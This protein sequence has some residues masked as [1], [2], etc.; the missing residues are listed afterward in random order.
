M[1]GRR[2]ID[3]G[4]VFLHLSVAAALIGGML[5]LAR[6]PIPAATVLLIAGGLFV[7]GRRT[8]PPVGPVLS[9]PTLPPPDAPDHA[10]PRATSSPDDER[11]EEIPHLPP[12][13]SGTAR[14]PWAPPAR[15]VRVLSRRR[16][17][18]ALQRA[19]LRAPDVRATLVSD[20]AS[21]HHP[22]AVAVFVEDE[23]VGDL[24]G[25]DV[26]D[27]GPALARA[28]CDI[29]AEALLTT[30]ALDVALPDP[31]GLVPANDV[32][33]GIVL[34][35]GAHLRVQPL[36]DDV[37]RAAA[38]EVF[39]RYPGGV[40][41]AVSV[42]SVR[43]GRRNEPVRAVRVDLDGVLVGRL[44]GPEADDLI[45]LLA[46]CEDRHRGVVAAA[47]QDGGGRLT[48]SCIRG[49]DADDTW[50]RTVR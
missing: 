2:R 18:A 40:W 28:G 35:H 29:A 42:T 16:H 48:L 33:D 27:Y 21:P 37:E 15:R 34:P 19:R 8:P 31:V 39:A 23:H 50:L 38:E 22:Y 32:P 6:Q 44:T 10:G 1:A 43:P 17:G 13:P 25:D 47:W 4:A 9:G 7:L 11:D 26:L 36:V 12:L 41:L 30:T 20:T 46:Y 14:R 45:P 49:A 3:R 24:D 5:G